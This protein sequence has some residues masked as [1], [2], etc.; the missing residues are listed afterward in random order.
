MEELLPRT[1]RRVLDVLQ[2]SQSIPSRRNPSPVQ[3]PDGHNGHLPAG[4][5]RGAEA[6]ETQKRISTRK[7]DTGEEEPNLAVMVPSMHQRPTQGL[8]CFVHLARRR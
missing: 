3:G 8:D 7:S 2:R 5:A 4:T 1:T 6:E